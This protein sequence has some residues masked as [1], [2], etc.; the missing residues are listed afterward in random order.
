MQLLNCKEYF[1]FL[2]IVKAFVL[3]MSA[4]LY[5][6]GCHEQTLAILVMSGR[7]MCVCGG[8]QKLSPKA[9]R[10]KNEVFFWLSAWF[11]W[12]IFCLGCCWVS[13]HN[14]CFMQIGQKKCSDMSHVVRGVL[15]LKMPY[16]GKRES[17]QA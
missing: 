9:S 17:R 5:P 4:H 12:A 13:Y 3:R 6:F 15:G 14:P 1:R 11:F 10:P 7:K 16:L 2:V 8:S